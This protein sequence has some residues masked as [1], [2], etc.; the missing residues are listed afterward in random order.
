MS[1]C[2]SRPFTHGCLF[3]PRYENSDPS[4]LV[5]FSDDLYG[6]DVF[7]K[8]LR[9]S[10]RDHGI[11]AMQTGI[12]DTPDEPGAAYSPLLRPLL[13][14][15]QLLQGAGFESIKSYNEAHG[16]FDAPWSYLIVFCNSHDQASWYANQAQVE[17]LLASRAVSTVSGDFPF[18]YFDG[19]TMQEYQDATRLTQERFCRTEPTPKHCHE[20]QGFDLERDEEGRVQPSSTLIVHDDSF[21]ILTRMANSSNSIVGSASDL[22]KAFEPFSHD[23]HGL[24]TVSFYGQH[25]FIVDGRRIGRIPNHSCE[26]NVLESSR[27]KS[28]AFF[29]PYLDRCAHGSPLC[30]YC[31]IMDCHSFI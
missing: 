25:A 24:S 16:N 10:L 22:W 27:N 3:S 5:E 19:S 9:N 30:M 1:T 6:N 31:C 7:A 4:S 26:G 29:D 17:L 13:T 14:M 15:Q 8:A 11:L 18:Y 12:S 21:G 28:S 23:D 20:G 2:E